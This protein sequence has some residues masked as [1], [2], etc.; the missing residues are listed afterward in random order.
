MSA[1]DIPRKQINISSATI[2]RA[3]FWAVLF[4]AVTAFI[5]S[6]FPM[7][8]HWYEIF[9]PAALALAGLKDPYSVQ[10][11]FNPP[12]ALIPVIPFALLPERIG[13]ALLGS[14]TLFAFGYVARRM[15][16]SWLVTV[17]FLLLPHTLYNA[18]QVNV[19][20]L[21]AIGFLMP[22]Q[23]GLFFVLIKPQIGFFIALFWLVEA[24]RKGGFR[25][26]VRVFMPVSIAF[27]ISFVVFGPYFMKSEGMILQEGKSFWPWS[28]PIGLVLL[29]LSLK[30]RKLGPSILAGPFLSPYTQPYTWPL[31]LLGLFPNKIFMLLGVIFLWIFQDPGSLYEIRTVL[32]VFIK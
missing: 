9:R 22:P 7:R 28:I 27:L 8:H 20:W 25:E 11:F 24:W 14:T 6:A 12:W 18:I 16:A 32:S 3:A 29:F 30:F 5:F 13:F 4:F 17:A 10:N 2:V 26:V 21:V 1:I 19:D 15:G 31:A 23:I